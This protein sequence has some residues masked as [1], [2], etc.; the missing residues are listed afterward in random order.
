MEYL[1]KGHM[2]SGSQSEGKASITMREYIDQTPLTLEQFFTVAIQLTQIVGDIHQRFIIHHMITTDNILITPDGKELSL[3]N[4]SCAQKWFADSSKDIHLTLIQKC[5]AYTSPEQTGRTSATVDYRTD[6]YSLGIVF[7]ELL[8]GKTPFIEN[9]T[10]TSKWIHSHIAKEAV[11][12][13]HQHDIIP[14]HVSNIVMKLLSKLKEERYQSAYGLM[15]DL[16]KSQYQYQQRHYSSSFK[17]G[18]KDVPSKLEFPK[19]IVGRES[20]QKHISDAFDRVVSSSCEAIFVS[21]ASGIGKTTLINQ[22]FNYLAA[23]NNGY[24]VKGKFE[25]LKKTIPYLPLIKAFKSLITQILTEEKGK[26]EIW[27][28]RFMTALGTNS[29]IIAKVIPEI[30]LIIGETP[31]MEPL[32]PAESQN[33]FA[34][35]FQTF[36][37]VFTENGSPLILFLD[38]L[39]WADQASLLLIKQ[40][41][42]REKGNLLGIFAY[43]DN[44]VNVDHPLMKLMNKISEQDVKTSHLQLKPLRKEESAEW[45]S[46]T[47]SC[48]RSECES[49]LHLLHSKTSGNPLFFKH[50]LQVIFEKQLLYF[51]NTQGKWKWDL[52]GIE[53]LDTAENTVQLLKGKWNRLSV[54]S[55]ELLKNA[56]CIGIE[57]QYS[58]LAKMNHVD[59]KD[60]L[61]T[62]NKLV[63]DRLIMKNTEGSG[64]YFFSHD[65]LWQTVYGLIPQEEKVRLHW[66]AGLVLLRSIPENERD[67]YV[68]TIVHQLNFSINHDRGQSDKMLLASLNLQ[69]GEKAKAAIANDSALTY[70]TRGMEWLGSDQW[71]EHYILSFSL[72]LKRAECEFLNLNIEYAE[73]LCAL[74]ISK[75]QS[76][77]DKIK[78]YQMKV[79]L[80]NHMQ[81]N[82]QAVEVG[83]EALSLLGVAMPENPKAIT[84]LLQW[85]KI[86]KHIDIKEMEANYNVPVQ[87]SEEQKLVRNILETTCIPSYVL[88]QKLYALLILEMFDNVAKYGNSKT[89]SLSY[90]NYA[91]FI[92]TGFGQY[93]AGYKFGKLALKMA[94]YYQNDKISGLIYFVFG[95]LLNHWNNHAETSIDYLEKS[96]ILNRQSGDLT[97]AGASI[98]FGINTRLVAGYPLNEISSMLPKSIELMKDMNLQI[99]IDYLSSLQDQL[100]VLMDPTVPL[101]DDREE[102]N[103]RKSAFEQYGEHD[104]AIFNF[105]AIRIQQ[106]FLTERY[107]LVLQ[108]AEMVK[109]IAAKILPG[110]LT[111]DY[112]FYYALAL[113]QSN[114]NRD[115]KR[116]LRSIVKKVKTWASICPSNFQHKYLLVKAE[117]ARH[118][119]RY[120]EAVQCYDK[121]IQSARRYGFIQHEALACQFAGKF[122]VKNGNREVGIKFLEDAE[123]LFSKWGA[124]GLGARIKERYLPKV[125]DSHSGEML[126]DVSQKIDVETIMEASSILVKEV[127][128]EKV[129]KNLM[130]LAI[131]HAGA[132]QGFFILERDGKLI[133]EGEAQSTETEILVRVLHSIPVDQSLSIPHSLVNYVV[134]TKEKLVFSNLSEEKMFMYNHYVMENKPKSSLCLPILNQSRVT[135][136]LYLENDLST[137]AFTSKHL[138]VLE[139]LTSQAAIS[140]DN[141]RLYA[142]MQ[143]LN[144]QLEEKVKERTRNLEQSQKETANAL[145]Q[146]SVLEERNRIAHEIHDSVGHALTSTIVQIEAGKRLIDKNPYLAI[147]KMELSQD[148]IRKGLD[149]IRRS[150]RLMRADKETDFNLIPSLRKL[151]EDT[152]NHADV[153]ISSN[154]TRLPQL[155]FSIG[156]VIYQALQEGLTNGIRH[157]ESTQFWFVLQEKDQNIVFTLQD[158]G[159]GSSE[160]VRCGFGLTVMREQIEKLNGAFEINSKPNK[161]FLLKITIPI[162][163]I[164]KT[165]QQKA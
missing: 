61:R 88:N 57:F 78:V 141:A 48:D 144:D 82:K 80:Y 108:E 49:L 83:L 140:I 67:G 162:N 134:R 41:F 129:L 23:D 143:Q 95:G 131:E 122:Q 64:S 87:I 59:Q 53:K 155:A 154:I 150:V 146:K 8:T 13:H 135:G 136:V 11:P 96:Y 12:P 152:E 114:P 132:T 145:A 46:Q 7:Y 30:E 153:Q 28:K 6:F 42:T 133:I 125:D 164:R 73:E 24:L 26:I 113:I 27:K 139:I 37:K 56:A 121:A 62:L 118:L 126:S 159:K 103:R 90:C 148:L 93:E 54:K 116:T 16:K 55:K 127:L 76:I 105:I 117:M 21:G 40:I 65:A 22:R 124:D 128:L 115:G 137:G 70:F 52:R 3:T 111:G 19:H 138:K 106:L 75:A 45:L 104:V 142:D 112:Y 15:N 31:Q 102:S 86:K 66:E 20:A 9:F 43:R 51:D 10:S 151:I 32:N 120:E 1:L 94:D 100:R 38:D 89:S 98:S 158:D 97:T 35:T 50:L 101:L 44:E 58:T 156:K 14:V 77:Q 119:K 71:E 130:H 63:Q 69:A 34:L 33:R 5:P 149:E 74:L 47:L 107:N 163:W 157:G 160:N 81:K 68:F 29:G 60:M 17:L 36:V 161:G 2:Q 147:E 18:T 165:G 92:T 109:K 85:L 110:I 123:R 79:W 4:F 99:F 39:Q 72:Y 91:L 84:I 25:S